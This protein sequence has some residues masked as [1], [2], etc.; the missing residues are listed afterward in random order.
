MHTWK[1]DQNIVWEHDCGI[2]NDYEEYKLLAPHFYCI[3]EQA[4]FTDTLHFPDYFHEGEADEWLPQLLRN[5]LCALESQQRVWRMAL[6]RSAE[7]SFDFVVF[8]RPDMVIHTPFDMELLV[9]PSLSYDVC[10]PSYHHFEGY[11]DRFAVLPFANGGKYA[12]RLNGIVS[13]RKNHGRIVSE[14]YLKYVVDK[15][16]P[17]V[18]FTDMHMRIVRPN[19]QEI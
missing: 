9:S 3:D 14:K 7:K 16:L 10:L 13:Y 12:E 8:V 5:H 4:K 11:N 19:G 1:T 18:H 6:A 15:E 17:R 2:A